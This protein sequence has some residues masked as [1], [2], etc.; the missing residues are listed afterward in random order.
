MLEIIKTIERYRGVMKV[1]INIKQKLRRALAALLAVLVAGTRLGNTF[2]GIVAPLEEATI[3]VSAESKSETDD[4]EDDVDSVGL[5]DGAEEDSVGVLS[6]ASADTQQLSD[7][8]IFDEG[9]SSKI[10][11]G[12]NYG[13]GGTTDGGGGSPVAPVNPGGGGGGGGGGSSS[14]G[15]G[16]GSHSSSSS[17]GLVSS[18]GTSAGVG[19]TAASTAV[20]AADGSTI[21]A[22]VSANGSVTASATGDAASSTVDSKTGAVGAAK[23]IEAATKDG[24]VGK[25]LNVKNAL[26]VSANDLKAIAGAGV[27]KLTAD[28]TQDG[29]VLARMYVPTSIKVNVKLGVHTDAKSTATATAV[30]NKFY[31]NANFKVVAYDQQGQFGAKVETAVKVDLSKIDIKNAV[32]YSYNAASNKLVKL[33]DVKITVDKN[34]YAHFSTTYAGNIIISDGVLSKT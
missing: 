6:E 9:S 29:K 17:T 27:T 14:G 10:F 25:T 2:S 24:K 30:I 11:A 32:L 28:T 3:D 22:Y 33:G 18:S 1:S 13:E 21:N 15:G 8:V 12:T 19:A 7:D 34:G 20:K 31:K 26:Y 4:V 16:G 23:A 5:L